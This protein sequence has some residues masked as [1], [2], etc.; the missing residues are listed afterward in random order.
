[1]YVHARTRKGFGSAR[2]G[3]SDKFRKL[4]KAVSKHITLP[5]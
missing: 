2:L 3:Y 4:N 5:R 1:M